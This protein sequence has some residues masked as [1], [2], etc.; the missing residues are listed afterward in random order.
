MELF[1]W[2]NLFLIIFVYFGYPLVL[3]V[4]GVFFKKKVEKSDFFP[5]LS[6][7][8][9]VYNEGKVLEDKFE[10]IFALDYPKENLEII[11]VLDGCTDNSK[12]IVSKYLEQG[13]RLIEQNTRQGKMAALNI[14]N[15][16][17]TGEILVYSDADII[18]DQ[19]A[20]RELVA[21]F[22]DERVGCVGGQ[23]KYLL[24]T[25]SGI[26]AGERL[27]F[28]Y[29]KFL[30]IK[31]SQLRSLLVVS[32]SIYA[33]RKDLIS[34]I[35]ESLADD[36]VNPIRVMSKGFDSIYEPKALAFGRASHIIKD[37]FLQR[38]RMVAQGMRG[39]LSELK[40]IMSMSG[41]RVFE[42]LFHKLFRWLMPFYLALVLIGS[43]LLREKTFY[44]VFF[45]VNVIFY[46]F[47]FLGY[48]LQRKNKKFKVFYVPFYFTLA[49]TAA[50]LG[51]MR[52]LCK[53]PKG[54][55]ER[56]QSTR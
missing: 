23:L 44:L 54:T 46:G 20:L 38:T 34:K 35:D 36:F 17:A 11:I 48:V 55:W 6:L 8:I 33:M 29:E 41:L 47:A 13:V 21:N 45:I 52:F 32:G 26:E 56:A 51:I 31:E 9:A 53:E 1:F 40:N 39:T 5:K 22:K 15:Q 7:I 14:A 30:R 49:N 42:F 24:Q 43:G 10:N 16:Q 3:I 2:A 28:R 12:Q 19:K 27:Y 18:F 37:E 4:L 25:D 50:L